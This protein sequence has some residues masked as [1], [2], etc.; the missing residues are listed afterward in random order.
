MSTVER[1][2]KLNDSIQ[3]HAAAS[4]KE[5]EMNMEIPSMLTMHTTQQILPVVAN[6]T[7]IG[8][9]RKRIEYYSDSDN[10]ED[11][12]HDLDALPM[13]TPEF[14][15]LSSPATPSTCDKSDVTMK[16]SSSPSPRDPQ[17]ILADKIASYV[18]ANSDESSPDPKV[19]V[20]INGKSFIWYIIAVEF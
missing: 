8:T 5:M 12:D 19:V 17:D 10:E 18:V 16:F 13:S 7:N 4:Q 2:K 15:L 1:V 6:K 14:Q 9:I 11:D 20:V 3:R